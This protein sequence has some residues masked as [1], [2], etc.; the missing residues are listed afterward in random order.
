MLASERR[1]PTVVNELL[2]YG[3]NV[4]HTGQYKQTALHKLLIAG[5][6]NT[7]FFYYNSNCVKLLTALNSKNGFNQIQNKRNYFRKK[8][9]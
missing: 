1:L 8:A 2:D 3:A 4:N 9:F 6:Y 7:I 5:K